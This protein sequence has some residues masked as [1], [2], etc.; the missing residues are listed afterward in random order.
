MGIRVDAAALDRQLKTAGCDSRRELTFHK[1]LLEDKLPLTIGGGIGQSR[2]SMFLLGKAHIGEVQVSTWDD[3]TIQTCHDAGHH[4]AVNLSNRKNGFPHWEA[5]FLLDCMAAASPPFGAA[6][7]W[8]R[9]L[10]WL[11]GRRASSQP[12]RMPAWKPASK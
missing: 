11:L 12:M 5:V 3:E 7:Q 8:V 10:L 2:L 6:G 4:S 9:S 1:L